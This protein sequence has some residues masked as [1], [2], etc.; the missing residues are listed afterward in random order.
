MMGV[1]FTRGEDEWNLE[2]EKIKIY[3]VFYSIRTIFVSELQY[4][5][6]EFT[7]KCWYSVGRGQAYNIYEASCFPVLSLQSRGPCRLPQKLSECET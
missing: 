5:N 7:G 6:R 4:V 1:I 3:F 2:S